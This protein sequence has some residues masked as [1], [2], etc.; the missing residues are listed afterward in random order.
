VN[1][2][3]VIALLNQEHLRASYGAVAGIIGGS[4]R[5]LMT[6]RPH[7]LADSWVVAARTNRKTGARRGWPTGY[8]DDEI[9][10][11]CFNQ[12]QANPGGFVSD[13]DQ[14]MQALGI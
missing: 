9:D 8:R 5:S 13:S 4:A 2:D 6:G 7:S 10:Q 14:L 11:D 1:L 3:D 12:I